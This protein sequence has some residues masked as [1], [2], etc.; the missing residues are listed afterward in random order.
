MPSWRSREK[1]TKM[2][3]RW[4]VLP[5]RTRRE[6]MR[7]ARDGK[8][9]PDP[10]VASV[11]EG[12]AQ[13]VVERPASRMF[14]GTAYKVVALICV[15]AL[16]YWLFGSSRSEEVSPLIVFPFITLFT[17]YGIRMVARQIISLS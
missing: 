4:L 7:L 11:A 17:N 14:L 15:Y 9:H 12:W 1:R 13:S 3:Q 2:E 16:V 10:Q 6:V 5:R 8:T